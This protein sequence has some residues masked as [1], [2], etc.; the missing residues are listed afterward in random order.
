MEQPKKK[1]VKIVEVCKVAPPP[2]V[3]A[4]PS[5]PDSSTCPKS[6]SLTYLDLLWLRI[7]PVQRLIFYEFPTPD[8]PNTNT[9]AFFNADILPRLKHSFSLTLQCFLP[10]A[11]NLTWPKTSLKPVLVYAEGDAVSLTVAESDADFYRLSGKDEL[12]EA[13]E[14]HPLVPTLA[15]SHDRT[16]VLALQVTLF[17]N[18]GL[19]IGIAMHHAVL[20]GKSMH[21]FLKTWANTCRSRGTLP[22]LKPFYDRSVIKD[23]AGLETIY[24]K[25]WLDSE[26]PNNRSVTCLEKFTKEVPS[27]LARGMFQLTRADIEKLRHMVKTQMAKN[28]DN[29]PLEHIS[30]FSLTYAYIWAC[31]AKVEGII[32]SEYQVLLGFAVDCRPRLEPPV[33]E[34]YIGNC[35]GLKVATIETIGYGGLEFWLTKAVKAIGEAVKSLESDGVLNGAEEWVSRWF[36]APNESRR[37][38]L[39]T[40]AGSPRFEIY[41]M[42]FG[43]GRPRKTDVVSID[44][45]GAISLSDSSGNGDRGVEVGLV[46]KKQQMEAFAPLF[47]QGLVDS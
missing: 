1:K 3:F 8:D 16:A 29:E 6:L 18:Q 41:S 14:Y 20:D 19:S 22:E 25:Q 45:N 37:V 26:G 34:T 44:M 24:T 5:P 10:L 11:G 23:P 12:F 4:A 27:D 31:L 36:C 35:T 7:P 32:N 40:V 39:Y 21:L 2:A 28:K 9:T 33:P 43:W 47:A 42:D 17:P 13:R 38:R 30:S 15:M 46:L